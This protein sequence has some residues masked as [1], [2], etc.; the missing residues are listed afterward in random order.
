VPDSSSSDSSLLTTIT[1]RRGG[2][3]PLRGSS[4]DSPRRVCWVEYTAQLVSVVCKSPI[5]GRSMPSTVRAPVIT[6]GVMLLKA[7]SMSI[8][9]AKE[10][11]LFICFYGTHVVRWRVGLGWYVA[12][13]RCQLAFPGSG[14]IPPRVELLD[15]TIPQSPHA[16]YLGLILDKRL[17]WKQLRKLNWLLKPTIKLSLGNK[18]LLFKTI[19]VSSMTY[20]I[21]LWG[22]ASVSNVMK[23]Q[24]VQ[25][26]A[27]RMIAGAPWYV[28]NDALTT[29]LHVPSV[30]EQINRH[31]SR[32]NDRLTAHIN[33]LVASLVHPRTRRRLKRRHRGDLWTRGRQISRVLSQ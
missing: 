3:I 24:R 25:N 17:T 23:V 13:C 26:R 15:I 2:S 6:I 32:Y 14:K 30:R 7:P 28:R 5:I 19:V 22:M 9:A 11:S 20:C 4:T 16:Q 18:V 21:Q 29:D 10:Y 12:R 1:H 8:K 27:L 33:H 31:S